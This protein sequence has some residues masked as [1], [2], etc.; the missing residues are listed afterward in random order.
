MESKIIV[1]GKNYSELEEVV[2]IL[3]KNGFKLNCSINKKYICI[4]FVNKI[5]DL[6]YSDIE[7]TNTSS[8]SISIYNYFKNE[9]FKHLNNTVEDIVYEYKGNIIRFYNNNY[10]VKIGSAYIGL[11]SIYDIIELIETM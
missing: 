3:I 2:N 9:R 7:N 1:V 5:I 8:D 10:N 4:D 6:D 11:P